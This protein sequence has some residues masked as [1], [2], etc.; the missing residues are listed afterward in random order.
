MTTYKIPIEIFELFEMN[1]DGSPISIKEMMSDKME[2][3]FSIDTGCHLFIKATL[4]TRK[5]VD[6]IVDTGAS[7]S[8]F[9]FNLAA[10]Y[11]EHIKLDDEI[12]SSGVNAAMDLQMGVLK[13]CKLG[14][15]VIENYAVGLTDLSHINTIYGQLG[16][17]LIWGMIGG[18]FLNM[19]KAQIDYGKKVLVLKK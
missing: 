18:D 9:D 12:F 10:K 3:A 14:D 5:T 19:F 16:G 6:L 7:K 11:I 8:I 13:R 2:S 1:T 4:G 17:K 15:L